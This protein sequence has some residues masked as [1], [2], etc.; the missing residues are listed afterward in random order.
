MTREDV[1]AVAVLAVGTLA[2]KRLAVPKNRDK[3][4][5]VENARELLILAL[6]EVSEALDALERGAPVEEVL[7]EIGDV[8]AFCGLAAWRVMDDAQANASPSAPVRIE[9]RP[10]PIGCPTC[11]TVM[12]AVLRQGDRID[13]VCPRCVR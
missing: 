2:Q 11:R 13:V 7:A 1:E 4:V 12:W 10:M 6:V 5:P 8:A 3:G 9:P